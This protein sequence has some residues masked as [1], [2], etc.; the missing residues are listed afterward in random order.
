MSRFRIRAKNLFLTYPQCDADKDE[1]LSK[2]RI[3]FPLDLEWAVVAVEAHKDG[4]PHLH[5]V[6]ALKESFYTSKK[7][8][9]DQLTGKHGNYQSARSLVKVLKYVVKDDN[10]SSTGI[11]VEEYLELAKNKKSTKSAIIARRI[12]K[13]KIE[14]KEL[15][16]EYPGFVMMNLSKIVAFKQFISTT[17]QSEKKPWFGVDDVAVQCGE[18]LAIA[19]WLN[20]NIKQDRQFKQPQL[21]IYGMPNTG[22]TSLINQLEEYLRIYYLPVESFYDSYMDDEYDLIVIDEFRGQKTITFLNKLLQG[23]PMPMP[24]KGSQYQKNA[25]LPVIILSNYAPDCAYKNIDYIQAQALDKRLDIIEVKNFISLT[26]VKDEETRQ[27]HQE[28]SL[29]AED[30]LSE[31]IPRVERPLSQNQVI[32]RQ[33]EDMVIVTSQSTPSTQPVAMFDPQDGELSEHGSLSSESMEAMDDAFI[34]SEFY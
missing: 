15:V 3:M 33:P 12:H 1:V 31:E 29:L 25:N 23:S 4:T 14:V 9:F 5:C 30:M 27:L 19:E 2:I 16:D 32:L 17:N 22:K 21:Y 20:K 18:D 11:D 26:F 34:N 6:I 28:F 24:K 13:E 7:D 8:H 10:Y